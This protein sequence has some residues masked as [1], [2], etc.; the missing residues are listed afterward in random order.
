M[1]RH[2]SKYDKIQRSKKKNLVNVA[3]LLLSAIIVAA[4]LFNCSHDDSNNY[5][6][7]NMTSGFGS[8][9]S[10]RVLSTNI[11]NIS[12]FHKIEGGGA[13]T[14]SLAFT[15]PTQQREFLAL[16]G[17]H[18]MPPSYL[19]QNTST[20]TFL[21]GN[22]ANE[23]PLLSLFDQL[24]DIVDSNERVA[25]DADADGQRRA[26]IAK[27]IQDDLV[28]FCAMGSGFASAYIDHGQVKLSNSNSIQICNNSS[29]VI[30]V[31]LDRISTAT[32]RGGDGEILK[33]T[34]D[35]DEGAEGASNGNSNSAPSSRIK[36]I[37]S[38][39]L[40]LGNTD[41][42]RK[43]STSML[44]LL[45]SQSKDLHKLTSVENSRNYS[46]WKGSELY[47][48][49]REEEKIS[50][51]RGHSHV[52]NIWE[53]SCSGHNDIIEIYNDENN[54]MLK[55]NAGYCSREGGV[56]CC[57]VEFTKGE[58]TA[59]NGA[60][61]DLLLRHAI[62]E[63]DQNK[64]SNKIKN[65]MVSHN[66]KKGGVKKNAFASESVQHSSDSVSH[67]LVSS[68]V[69]DPQ[70]FTNPLM[71]P[72]TTQLFNVM[73]ENDCLPSPNC[74][75]CLKRQKSQEFEH[76]C[77]TCSKQC[78]CYCKCLCK[79]RPHKRPTKDMH[80]YVPTSKSRKNTQRLVPKIIH[81]TYI[82]QPTKED[83]PNF[84]RL[85]SS[86]EQSGNDWEYRFYDDEAIENFL[87]EYFPPEVREAY[88]ALDPGAYK[89]DLF[90]YCVLLIRGGVYADVDVLLSA[91]LNKLVENDVGFM[92]PV[93]SPGRDEGSG[94]CVWNGFLAA[95][96]GHPFIAKAIEMAVNVI[97]NRYTSVDIDG[98]LCP[99][100]NLDHS[101]HWDLLYITGPCLLGAA[102]NSVVGNHLQEEITAGEINV[103]ELSM[104]HNS[105]AAVPG[106]TVILGQN[107]EDM[108]AHLFTWI[109]R[110]IIVA[111]TDMPDYEDDKKSSKHYSDYTKRNSIFGLENIYKDLTPADEMIQ[112]VVK[113]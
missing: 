84:S 14:V 88:D 59:S 65:N 34:D 47:R 37:N 85:V 56:P 55:S 21:Y 16:Q 78:G 7:T 75:K 112:L 44:N 61:V 13:P 92:V 22:D 63:L 43:V 110:N 26:Q 99:N 52:W 74:H 20:N 109:E 54:V 68:V 1:I 71:L 19:G 31:E 23:N 8:K 32:D 105:K 97:R 42:G 50:K 46:I 102:I 2:S 103:W 4:G 48:L 38:S 70:D 33:I 5:D 106:R 87:G 49:V 101:H 35:K 24:G 81:Q 77:S 29:C 96:P 83:Y 28:K 79:V 64:N 73:L 15:T 93:D 40:V 98:M 82:E 25:A 94:S 30:E 10:F 12:H 62:D 39:F 51:G 72:G 9:Q 36:L 6:A 104:P 100:V 69:I 67:N 58:G 45:L 111:S 66:V 113:Q 95:A 17:D 89:A 27:T 57:Q 41:S 18:C 90:R 11:G 53:S 3:K 91:D 80:V 60:N 107:K 86:W 108:G 76:Q